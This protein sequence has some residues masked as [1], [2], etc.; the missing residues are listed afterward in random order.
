MTL[1]GIVSGPFAGT[2]G[3]A[4]HIRD[5]EWKVDSVGWG[6]HA[7]IACSTKQM[8][9]VPK[10]WLQEASSKKI[11][12]ISIME[13]FEGPDVT[14]GVTPLVA[15]TD[16]SNP[17]GTL[18]VNSWWGQKLYPVM[19]EKLQVLLMTMTRSPGELA[20]F[21][22]QQVC[23][24]LVFS[25]GDKGTQLQPRGYVGPWGHQEQLYWPCLF[26]G[27]G[28]DQQTLSVWCQAQ[29]MNGARSWRTHRSRVILLRRATQLMLSGQHPVEPQPPPPP[30]MPSKPFNPF[31]QSTVEIEEVFNEDE[32]QVIDAPEHFLL[33]DSEPDEMD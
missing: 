7:P 22:G 16:A 10:E 15:F 17:P 13:L 18:Q 2:R 33:Y 8:R 11:D 20:Y 9:L 32:F 26:V 30:P 24:G 12:K 25:D 23:C 6:C 5:E 1:V 14:A 21:R 27:T 3:Y 19:Y 28:E 31:E 29:A 4:T